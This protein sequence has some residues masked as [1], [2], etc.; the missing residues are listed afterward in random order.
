MTLR[1]KAREY[2]LQMLFQWEMSG[3]E[4]WR[5]ESLFW[6]NVKAEKDTRSFANRLLE[7]A[8]ASI[9]ECD[10]LIEKHATNWRLDRLAAID[11]ALL[12][13][14]IHELRE[15]ETPFKVVI[16]EAVELA[17]KYSS[18]EAPAFVNG[19]LD[20]VQKSLATRH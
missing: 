15:G 10:A 8:V 6:K 11:R 7:G 2:A 20:A 19:V 12:R 13:L 17:K 14:A 18:D 4:P 3:Q 9:K 5:V 16:H 1:R